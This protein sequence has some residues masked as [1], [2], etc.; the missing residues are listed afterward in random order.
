MSINNNGKLNRKAGETYNTQAPSEYFWHNSSKKFEQYTAQIE[1]C[2]L[3]RK[4]LP[5]NAV[6]YFTA[7]SLGIFA[8][9]TPK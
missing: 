5:E 8:V 7:N 4:S 6:R 3:T 1:N 2:Q 9:Q